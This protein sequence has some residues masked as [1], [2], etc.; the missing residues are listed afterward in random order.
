MLTLLRMATGEGWNDIM[1]AYFLQ[2]D[3]T[4]TDSF[5]CSLS[6]SVCLCS[7]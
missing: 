3:C 2:P 5:V 7:S 4:P 1:K 6:L